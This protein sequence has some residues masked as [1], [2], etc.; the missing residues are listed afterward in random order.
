MTEFMSSRPPFK[1]DFLIPANVYQVLRAI[2]QKKQTEV[3]ADLEKRHR[4]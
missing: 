3:I 2:P 4:M 1:L